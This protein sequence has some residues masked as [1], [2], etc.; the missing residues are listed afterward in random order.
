MHILYLCI[1]FAIKLSNIIIL[2]SLKLI[3][4]ELNNSKLLANADSDEKEKYDRKVREHLR[5]VADTALG[6]ASKYEFRYNVVKDIYEYR[7]IDD[8]DVDFKVVDQAAINSLDLEMKAMGIYSK[9]T[10][11]A[12]MVKSSATEFY[13]PIRSY[14][15]KVKGTWDG[16]DRI[17]S[18]LR[19]INCSDYLQKMGHI[20]LRAMVAQMMGFDKQHANS[21]MFVL[22]SPTQGLHKSTF[23][24]NLLPAE[25]QEYYTDDFSLNQKALAL[26]KTVEFAIINDDE[27]DKE[28]PKK[29][30]LMKTLLQC[31]KPSYRGAYKHHINTLPRTASFV[32][33]SNSRELLSDPTGSRRFLIVEPDSMIDINNINHDQIYAQLIDEL[34]RGEA[35]YFSK[36]DEKILQEHNKAYYRKSALEE[37][38]VRYFRKPSE[39]ENGELYS[40]K[41]I[42]GI[43]GKH[44]PKLIRESS[45]RT[46]S[47][48]AKRIFGDPKRKNAGNYHEL[49]LV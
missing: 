27:M 13:H 43:L 31:M 35:Y 14:I 8:S 38:L 17:C 33:T 41:E 37:A 23:M 21:V 19:R 32:G 16:Q 29:A 6:L 48:A 7:K 28:S 42:M 24:R 18:F 45:V 11:I 34:E 12:D 20:W 44:L 15:N 46:V 3:A 26:R 4:E 22:V 36:E 2:R 47:I 40:I 49:I 39:G 5:P 9:N 1:I 10:L 25:L 30:P